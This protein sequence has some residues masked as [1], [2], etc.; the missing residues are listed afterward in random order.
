MSS[1]NTQ[2]LELN[3]VRSL[4]FYFIPRSFT[5]VNICAI[6]YAGKVTHPGSGILSCMQVL[7]MPIRW[8][9][10]CYLDNQRGT[11]FHPRCSEL[12]AEIRKN[13]LTVKEHIYIV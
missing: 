12:N 4:P 1:P 6:I 2:L 7:R 9:K 5:E 13:A 8:L 10:H 3:H 11:E